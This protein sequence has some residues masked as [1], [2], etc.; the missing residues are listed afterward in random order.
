MQKP[1]MIVNILIRY[2]YGR[3]KVSETPASGRTP[4]HV[5]YSRIPDSII[6]E[7]GISADVKHTFLMSVGPDQNETKLFYEQGSYFYNA[8][9]LS[10]NISIRMIMFT[11]NNRT[12]YS[13]INFFYYHL[14]CRV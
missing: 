11:S 5:Y 9:F 4:V 1:F 7:S 8:Y 10:V 6:V 2:M 3:T 14:I 12:N 13:R